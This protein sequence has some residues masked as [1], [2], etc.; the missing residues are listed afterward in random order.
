MDRGHIADPAC[1]IDSTVGMRRPQSC[2]IFATTMKTTCANAPDIL[3]D[4]ARPMRLNRSQPRSPSQESPS[5]DARTFW[6]RRSTCL[7]RSFRFG[8]PA[9]SPRFPA[10]VTAQSSR[11]PSYSNPGPAGH[12]GKRLRACLKNRSG[13]ELRARRGQWRGSPRT[14]A[15]LLC[16]DSTKAHI[17]EKSVTEEQQLVRRSLGEG[18]SQ[19]HC[20][21]ARPAEIFLRHALKVT[22]GK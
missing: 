3:N 15:A 22:K 20:P 19:R 9:P 8:S 16:S 10:V 11:P 2:A 13:K 5:R 4:W 17:R 12:R 18:G 14:R 1:A 6:P 21:A 7:S